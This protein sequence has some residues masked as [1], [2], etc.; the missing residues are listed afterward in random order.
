MTSLSSLTS[1]Y[2]TGYH[3]VQNATIESILNPQ[4]ASIRAEP[5]PA[6]ITT[7]STA[8]SITL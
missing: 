3:P 7:S 5:P 6:A 4:S 1:C 2:F 8:P